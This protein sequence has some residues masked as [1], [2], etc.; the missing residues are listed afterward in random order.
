MSSIA[1]LRAKL[2]ES[3]A[4]ADNNNQKTRK[5][6]GGDNAS[7]PFWN[8]PVGQ[9][10]TLRFVP[11]AD[12][13]NDYFWVKRE[14]IKLP[15]AGVIGGD[16]PTE[17]DVE[18]TVPCIDMFGMQCPIIAETRPWWNDDAKKALAR[19]YYKK[20]SWIFN[21]F[22]INSAIEEEEVPENPI[23]RF[24][25]NKSLYDIIYEALLDEELVDMPT[26]F[27]GGR[28]F[29]IKKTMKK[30]PDGE[31]ANYGT[32]KFAMNPRALSEVERAAL[33]KYGS[34]NLKDALGAIPGAD[35]IEAI[36]AMFH[37]SL[38][39]NPFDMASFGQYYRPYG[40][41][42]GGSKTVPAQ[43][44]PS[45]VSASTPAIQEDVVDEVQTSTSTEVIKED[46]Q[47]IL[48]RL[49]MKASAAK[50]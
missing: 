39:G 5:S 17:K 22:V 30:S 32:S 9:T 12:P 21:G 13:T 46:T 7:F 24:V 40:T 33:D 10:T 25:I 34:H 49:R 31:W 8:T 4:K 16:F 38:A 26:D 42:A 1:D 14:V 47:A 41:S 37:D 28:D 11:D 20:K 19:L 43:S 3:A 18:V 23:R 6:S 36:K 48:A 50:A 15:F 44:T 35:A 27:N 29:S 45:V 2:R